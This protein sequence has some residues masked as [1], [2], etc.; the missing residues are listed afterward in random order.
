MIAAQTPIDL[1]EAL[2]GRLA[3]VLARLD[4]LKTKSDAQRAPALLDGWLPPKDLEVFPFV[5]VRPR[6]GVD[7]VQGAEQ[8]AKETIELIV[9]T[10]S[11]ENDGWKDV[12]QVLQAIRQDLAAAPTIANTAFEHV[13]PL[14][15]DIPEEQARPQWL[16]RATTIWQI[17]R[18]RRVE[19]RNPTED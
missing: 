14:T 5:I 8:D 1:H 18:P 16:G 6:S 15:W 4:R 3:P 19:A 11:D 2:K 9:G 17:P 12:L 10:Y 13:G 7:S